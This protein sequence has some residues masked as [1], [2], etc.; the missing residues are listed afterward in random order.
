MEKLLLVYNPNSG[1][2]NIAL[3]LD[4]IIEIF[5]SAGKIITLYRIGDP[6]NSIENVLKNGDFDGVV[7]CGG[8]GTLNESLTAPVT[9]FRVHSVCRT[10]YCF[11]PA[12]LRRAKPNVWILG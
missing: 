7:V 2:K 3:H 9:I 8:D 5:A 4:K 12:L 10:I 11:V 6:V 1:K